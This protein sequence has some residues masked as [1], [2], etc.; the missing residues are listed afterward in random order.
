MVRYYWQIDLLKRRFVSLSYA[1][2]GRTLNHLYLVQHP[3][4]VDEFLGTRRA[5]AYTFKKV[6][7]CERC[8]SERA[9][10]LVN[11]PTES[12]HSQQVN[13]PGV[14][15]YSGGCIL[16]IKNIKTGVLPQ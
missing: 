3:V 2:C 14:L 12:S 9:V 4:L 1:M 7:I 15:V 11:T 5:L 10:V 16:E 13:L 8:K 6:P